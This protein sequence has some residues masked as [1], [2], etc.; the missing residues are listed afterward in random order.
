MIIDVDQPVTFYS[1][2]LAFSFIHFPDQNV[3]KSGK[4][5]P[6]KNFNP[7][8]THIPHIDRFL[9]TADTDGTLHLNQAR[10]F[11]FRASILT[12]ARPNGG[13]AGSG[14]LAYAS[15]TNG[16]VSSRGPPSFVSS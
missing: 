12:G 10:R 2:S 14:A 13:S 8:P 3:I 7:P 11:S 1:L 5:S 4:D 9:S 6:I 15:R 16:G